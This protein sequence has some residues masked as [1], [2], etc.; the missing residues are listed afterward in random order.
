MALTRAEIQKNYR[1]RKNTNDVDDYLEKERKRTK[2]YYVPSKELS[3]TAR[4]ERNKTKLKTNRKNRQREKALLRNTTLELKY[5]F[6]N[7]AKGPKSKLKNSEQCQ[8]KAK[9]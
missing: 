2:Q 5:N 3:S 9:C 8:S 1:E 7:K 4:S 6:P